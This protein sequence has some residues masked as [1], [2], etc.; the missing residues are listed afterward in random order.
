[1]RRPNTEARAVREVCAALREA[2]LRRARTDG[3]TGMSGRRSK[4]KG[5]RREVEFVELHK[6]LGLDAHRVPLS[7]AVAG[8]KGDLRIG[9]RG[10][11][12]S[13]EV[14]GRATGGGFVTLEKWLGD[15]DLLLLKRDRTDPLVV[16]P[17]AT[18]A[19]LVGGSD[20]EEAQS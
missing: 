4:S 8:Y 7:G 13:A 14:K 2:V 6:S 12:L 5:Y 17:W 1:M 20:E 15:N 16:L 11:T 9:V 19:W 18:W 3:V 10:V